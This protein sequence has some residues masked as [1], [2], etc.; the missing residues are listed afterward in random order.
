MRATFL[1]VGEAFDENRK[2]TSLFVE[3]DG[4]SMVLDCGA[5]SGV[6]AWRYSE[7]PIEIDAVYI[8]HFHGDHFLGL[9]FFITRSVE[10]RR[11]KPLRI[12]GQSGVQNRVEQAVNLAYPNALAKA[13][14]PINYIECSAETDVSLSD[15]RLRF[16]ETDHG[17]PCLSIRVD[18]TSG[19]LFY[20]G[21]GAPTEASKKLASGCDVI[22]QESFTLES[23]GKGHGSFADAVSLA[24][25]AEARVL[26]CVH[27]HRQ[28]RSNAVDVIK[29]LIDEVG[30]L[31]V[32]TPEV[33]DI[34]VLSDSS[35]ATFLSK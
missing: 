26:A 35:A 29:N 1:G 19:S 23:T 25:Q 8:S 9:P 33:G 7:S 31:L 2:N 10:E 15:V 16:A 12:I 6:A 13:K 5:S 34:V 3:T 4:F 14:F 30:N 27:V 11:T 20:S 22:V 18:H 21:D 28:I 32:A 17:M 24:Q